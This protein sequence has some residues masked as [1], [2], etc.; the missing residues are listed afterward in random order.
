MVVVKPTAGAR[1]MET[2]R[3]TEP[4][5]VRTEAIKDTPQALVQAEPQVTKVA[6]QVAQATSVIVATQAGTVE[7]ATAAT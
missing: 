4:A 2:P 5:Q 6:R 7:K 3:G 1:R